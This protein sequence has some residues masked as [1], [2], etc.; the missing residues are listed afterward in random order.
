MGTFALFLFCMSLIGCLVLN[1]SILY[2]LAAGFFIFCAYGVAMGFSIG[3]LL[4]EAFEGVKTAKNVLKTFVFIGMLTALW[5]AAGT[6]PVIICYSAGLISP[7][8]FLLMAFLL[9]CVVSVLTGTAF[10][11]AATMGVIC[12]AMSSAMGINPALSGGAII[13]GIFFGDRCS[14]VSTSALLVSELSATDIYKNIKAMT[15][16]AAVPFAITCAVYIVLGMFTDAG[17]GTVDIAGMFE[18][19]FNLHWAALLPAA[20]ILI[21]SA[22]KAKVRTNMLVSIVFAFFI[23]IFVQNMEIS[24]ILRLM[25]LGYSAKD[26]Q[27]A[28][29]LN[30]GG[31][32]S[33]A[34]VAAIVCL[35]SSYAGL[36][37]ATGLLD[38]LKGAVKRL[39]EKTTA[40]SAIT[41]GSVVTSMIACNQ[42]LAIML[43]H[44]ICAEIEPDNYKF[45]I[46]LENSVVLI[47]PLIPWSIASAVPLSTI[48]AP[49]TGLFA[50]CFL[51]LVPLWSLITE[52]AGKYRFKSKQ[53]AL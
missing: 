52:A 16:S 5:R 3:E 2:A 45:A 51:Y 29:M 44:Q 28:E 20:A 1:I 7:K 49:A 25:V 34:K 48:S 47:A 30:G 21:M 32:V 4:K 23:C 11:T 39:S 18:S 10:G 31:I 8:V 26:A 38:G 19:S 42:T 17:A 36:F 43:T 6:V 33:M 22:L 14:P 27:M 46:D 13:S 9:N 12:M 41:V 53:S 15:I 40:R 50:A 24:E 37:K 35:S